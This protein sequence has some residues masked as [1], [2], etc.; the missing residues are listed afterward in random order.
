MQIVIAVFVWYCT[1]QALYWPIIMKPGTE[2]YWWQNKLAAHIGYYVGLP[3][4]F[5]AVI[6][7]FS[8]LAQMVF[9][10]S[11]TTA[12]TIGIYFLA[13]IV[14]RGFMRLVKA[15]GNRWSFAVIGIWMEI[16]LSTFTG[17]VGPTFAGDNQGSSSLL[18]KIDR[19]AVYTKETDKES[20][21]W[22]LPEENN[23]VINLNKYEAPLKVEDLNRDLVV[24][25]WV[26]AFQGEE[27]V[28]ELYQIDLR[29]KSGGLKISTMSPV[30]Q[31]TGLSGNPLGVVKIIDLDG[32]GFNE[33]LVDSFTHPSY[34]S[35]YEAG[36][37]L[38]VDIYELKTFL[39]LNNSRYKSFHREKQRE[40][41]N[42]V[43]SLRQKKLKLEEELA[44]ESKQ[45]PEEHLIRYEVKIRE[46]DDQIRIYR[47]WLTRIAGLIGN[48]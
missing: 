27:I 1:V 26:A 12:W 4:W 16:A 30:I 22:S 37:V 25:V 45:A 42:A 40:I 35:L 5:L 10:G 24:E 41:L 36:E 9:V 23:I 44:I 46:V 13:G 6:S 8:G 11:A 21:S 19:Y 34:G 7:P 47:T 31:A 33:L 20:T 38:W 32:D 43:E 14:K 17:T 48:K 3:V 18:G 28:V 15:A 29:K 39:K 2:L